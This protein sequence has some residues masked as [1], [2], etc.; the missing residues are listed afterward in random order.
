MLRLLL[1][2]K[3]SENIRCHILEMCDQFQGLYT[4]AHQQ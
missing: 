2:D 1:L 4:S 3:G